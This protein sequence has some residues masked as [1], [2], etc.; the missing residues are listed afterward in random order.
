MWG[1]QEDQGSTG[2]APALPQRRQ[3]G[4]TNRREL[5]CGHGAGRCAGYDTLH[6]NTQDEGER[7]GDDEVVAGSVKPRAGSRDPASS[8]QLRP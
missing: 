3:P 1:G 8:Y 5:E 6:R 2:L 7:R 4:T